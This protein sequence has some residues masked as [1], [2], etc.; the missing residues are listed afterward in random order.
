MQD[1]FDCAGAPF[2]N[3]SAGLNEQMEK[4]LPNNL[5]SVID[6]AVQ[7]VD[8]RVKQFK[9]GLSKKDPKV[10][11]MQKL[12]GIPKSTFDTDKPIDVPRDKPEK[13]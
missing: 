6:Q 12:A 2:D 5:K 9:K 13:M 11:R 1:Y 10:D 3:L 8:R 4:S 7:K